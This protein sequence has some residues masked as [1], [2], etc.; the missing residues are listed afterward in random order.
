MVLSDHPSRCQ[1]FVV[2]GDVM[3]AV[4]HNEW[5]VTEQAVSSSWPTVRWLMSRR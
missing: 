4:V 1:K 5:V 3:L 2:P